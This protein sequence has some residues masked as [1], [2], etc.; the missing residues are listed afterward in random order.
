MGEIDVFD[1]TVCSA[2]SGKNIVPVVQIDKRHSNIELLTLKRLV[3]VVTVHRQC[4]LLKLE[5]FWGNLGCGY[6][7]RKHAP[8]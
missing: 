6:F 2:H 7:F 8:A 5:R 1:G 4:H 3:S